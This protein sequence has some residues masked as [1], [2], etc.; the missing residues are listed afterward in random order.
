MFKILH[1]IVI[2]CRNLE[3]VTI[4][5]HDLFRNSTFTNPILISVNS[6]R[7]HKRILHKKTETNSYLYNNQVRVYL[8]SRSSSNSIANHAPAPH[9]SA[10]STHFNSD[11]IWISVKSD[12]DHKSRISS[13]NIV[14]NDKRIRCSSYEFYLYKEDKSR[15]LFD[16]PIMWPVKHLVLTMNQ[17]LTGPGKK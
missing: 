8:V 4:S 15:V 16:K 13:T 7:D 11:P 12:G 17:M 1:R 5:N 10:K 6:D 9:A 14:S 3:I 2:I